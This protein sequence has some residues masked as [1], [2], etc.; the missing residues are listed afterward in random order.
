[1]ETV[2]NLLTKLS[3][4]YWSPKHPTEYV[5]MSENR[6][7]GAGLVAKENYAAFNLAWLKCYGKLQ[8]QEDHMTFVRAFAQAK[9]LTELLVDGQLLSWIVTTKTQKEFMHWYMHA[10]S[11]PNQLRSYMLSIVEYEIQQLRRV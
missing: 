8:T 7:V 3:S 11:I 4:Y 10:A 6:V 2:R 9:P 5:F 1:M